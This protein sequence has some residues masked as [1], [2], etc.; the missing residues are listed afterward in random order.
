MITPFNSIWLICQN[1]LSYQPRSLGGKTEEHSPEIDLDRSYKSRSE[2]WLIDCPFVPF[3]I[4]E[5]GR[6][7]PSDHWDLLLGETQL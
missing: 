7:D 3:P 4:H 5:L 6:N 1:D 2:S